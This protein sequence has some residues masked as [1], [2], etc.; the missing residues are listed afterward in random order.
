MA[1]SILRAAFSNDSRV[2]LYAEDEL[3]MDHIAVYRIPI[4]REFQTE[5]GNRE[6]SVT[7]AY[8]PPVRHSR[9]DYAGLDMNFRLIRG[10]SPDQ[11]FEH[12][13][14]R[15][16]ADGPV[17]ELEARFQCKLEPGPQQRERSTVQTGRK[18]FRRDVSQYGDDYYLV[19][20]CA[21]GWAAG[22]DRQRFAVVVEISHK[23]QVQLYERIRQRA[24][25]TA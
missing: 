20:R 18:I 4:P 16:T 10:C 8:D 19:V 6:I 14:R 5:P 24:R 2:V 13:R 21:S 22:V 17:P 23:A 7:L 1:S 3:I 9:S 15:V 11:I 12:Y 25:L